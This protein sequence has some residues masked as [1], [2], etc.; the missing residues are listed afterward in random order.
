MGALA[1]VRTVRAIPQ[2]ARWLVKRLARL[3]PEKTEGSKQTAVGQMKPQQ[4][5]EHNR[6]T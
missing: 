4:F 3:G 5:K 6:N 2:E 1:G